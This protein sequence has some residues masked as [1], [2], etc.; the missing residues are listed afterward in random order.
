MTISEFSK[1]QKKVLNWWS[2]NSPDRTKCAII[3]DGSVR[4]GKTLAMTISFILWAM[5]HF[6]NTA[7]HCR[8]YYFGDKQV[9]VSGK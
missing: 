7:K 2:K 3:C 5:G 6:S 1:K 9:R 8:S 4:S